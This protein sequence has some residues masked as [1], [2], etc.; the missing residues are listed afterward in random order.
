M[1]KILIN[2]S[3]VMLAFLIVLCS[4]PVIVSEADNAVMSR[5]THDYAAEALSPKDYAIYK[6]L[7]NEIIKIADGDRTSTVIEVPI[8]MFG[9]ATTLTDADLSL[10]EPVY[11]SVNGEIVFNESAYNEAA[12]AI[13]ERYALDQERIV[14]ALWSDCP[15][16]MYWS[17]RYYTEFPDEVCFTYSYISDTGLQY[18]P[19]YTYDNN[20]DQNEA[21]LTTVFTIT[22]TGIRVLFKVAPDYQ[23]SGE[24]TIDTSKTAVISE[25]VKNARRIVE[26]AKDLSDHDKLLYYKDAICSRVSYNTDALVAWDYE[27]YGSIQPW[28]MIYVFDDDTSN[29]VVCEGY[30]KAFKYLCDLT[31]FDSPLIRC[32]LIVGTLSFDLGEV[33]HVWN[34]VTMPDG[35]NYLVDLTNC[36][37]D[38][39]GYPDKLFLAGNTNDDINGWFEYDLASGYFRY[40]YS[41]KVLD[42]FY[43]ERLTLADYSYE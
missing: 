16:D 18:D 17:T 43:P 15:Y 39:A 11:S 4:V 34:I 31:E 35:N 38:T 28:Q 27:H 29:Q 33:E 42:L 5:G 41:E 8:S 20:D 21:A 9:F 7:K 6:Y 3:A 26:E 22:T 19:A 25:A 32:I 23:D 24:Y 12:A 10:S 13:A 37:E 1:K 14:D 2:T 40:R 30:S 36:D